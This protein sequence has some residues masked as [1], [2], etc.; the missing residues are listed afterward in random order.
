MDPIYV[1]IAE[2][3]RALFTK[4]ENIA[5]MVSIL[6]NVGMALFI[7][8]SKT[9]DREDRK[10]LIGTLTGLTEALNNVR[11]VIAANTLKG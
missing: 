10:A 4:P 11:I 1:A 2:V 3:I 9:E 7:L 6:A 8:R 5:L